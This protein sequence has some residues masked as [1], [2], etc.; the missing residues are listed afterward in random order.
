MLRCR[1]IILFFFILI[2]YRS[3]AQQFVNGFKRFG[4]AEGVPNSNNYKIFE[5]SDHFLWLST[6]SGLYRFDGYRFTP[7]FSKRNDSATLSSNVIEDIEE[8]RLGNLWVT[9]F[10]RGVNRLDRKT[11][12]WKQYAHPTKDDNTFYRA[13]DLFK[14]YLGRLWLGTNSRGLLLYD[15]KQ[16]SFLQFIPDSTKNYTGDVRFENDV[17]SITADAADPTILWLACTDGLY[18]FDTKGKK[19]TSYKNIKNNKIEWINISF[20]TIYVQDKQNIWLGAWGGGLIH[21]NIQTSQFTNYPPSKQ[22][23]AK[24]N[25]ARNI[26][27]AIA[28]CSDSSLY[29]STAND[30]LLEFNLNHKKFLLISGTQTQNE[31]NTTQLFNS[32]THTSDGST[33]ICS[34]GNIFQKHPVY[35]R[36]GKFQSFYQPKEKFVYSPSLIDVL[37][38]KDTRQYW[39]SCNAGYGVYIYD[40]SFN[41][42][43]SVAIENFTA[44]R[45]LRN[46]VLDASGTTWLLSKDFPYLYYYDKVKDRFLNAAPK[47]KDPAFINSGL[48]K[49]ATDSKGNVWFVNN[50]EFLKWDPVKK[51]LQ[52][53]S[54]NDAENNTV[55]GGWQ[56]VKL[57]FDADDNPWLASNTGL[58]H[59]NQSKAE[60]L[61]LYSQPNNNQSLANTFVESI[62]F[63]KKGICWIAPMDEGLQLYDPSIKKFINNYNQ[64]EGFFAARVH[65]VVTDSKGDLWI[66]GNNGLARYDEKQDQWFTF[67]REDGLPTDN[68][69]GAAF[70]MDDGTM[71]LGVQDGFIHWNIHSLP[72]NNQNPIVY[73]NRLVSGGKELSVE[74]NK[75]NLPSSAKEISIDFSAISIVMGNRTKFYYKILPRQKE[76]VATT[77]RTLSLAAITSGKF[78]LL[79][80]AVNSDGIESEVKQITISVAFPFWKTGWFKILCVLIIAGTIY[81]FAKWR[82]NTIRKEE[83]NKAIFKSQM[84]EM[85]MKALRSQMNPHFIFNCINSID[86]LIQSN[87]KYSATVYLNKFAK[88]IRNILDS[89][90]QNTVTLAKDLDT[91]KLY[92]ELEQLRHENKFTAEIKADDALLQDDYKVPPLIIQPFAENA[93][94]HGIRY[95]PDNNGKLSISVIKQN[96]FLKYSIEDNGVGR[97]TFKSPEQKEKI[98]YGIDMSNERVKLFNNEEKASV[99]IIDLLDNGKPAGTRV[100]VLLKIQ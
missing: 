8:D 58:Y 57:V 72:I 56:Q 88:L 23:Y 70:A 41:Y 89:S 26:I 38:R 25:R 21:F 1:L 53:F 69:Y 96:D 28:Y 77:E 86:G 94:L 78:T 18:R 6:E 44:D 91:L 93:I 97:N 7:Y 85:E 14:D 68:L 36:L 55:N 98:S 48:I 51:Q 10:G 24:Q 19:F 3:S 45:R 83:K 81:A 34:E 74:N 31:K 39:M 20:H 100:E 87:D 15:E 47:F 95:R 4:Q 37:Y 62:A 30:G 92:I 27:S 66:A 59:F 61:H 76:W 29:V 9:T 75:I 90:K 67:N 82:G 42:L 73:F 17:R 60:W 43:R 54:A 16:D 84:A 35:E 5:S 22:E 63:D 71:I 11:G 49:M 79:I 32:I 99:L 33:W 2:F 13:Y 50:K 65:D 12:K 52:I 46:I 40:S 80:K 64:S